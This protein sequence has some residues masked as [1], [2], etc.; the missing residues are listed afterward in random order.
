[1]YKVTNYQLHVWCSDVVP[2]W[3]VSYLELYL[4][5]YSTGIIL[6]LKM[7]RQLVNFY[8]NIEYI[9]KLCL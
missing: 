7:L 2:H 4:S 3:L 9:T 5:L 6:A 1:M 8:S